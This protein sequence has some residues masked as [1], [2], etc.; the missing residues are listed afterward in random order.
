MTA[1]RKFRL[2]GIG[3]AT[4]ALVLAGTS[5]A[6]AAPS[7]VYVSNTHS[8]STACRHTPVA[9]VQQGVDLVARGGTVTVCAGSY[10]ENVTIRKPLTLR[11]LSGSVIDPVVPQGVAIRVQADHVTVTG[12]TVTGAGDGV[13]VETDF[14]TIS[15]N[16]VTDT[17]GLGIGL[18]GTRNSVV[19]NNR[20]VGTLNGIYLADSGVAAARSNRIVGN[21]VT[22]S[23]G[24]AGIWIVDDTSFGVIGNVVQGNEVD[25][26]HDFFAGGITIVV[27]SEGGGVLRDNRLMGN[28]ASGNDHA[29]IEIIVADA[30]ADVSGNWIVGNNLGTNNVARSEPGDP[31]TTGVYLDSLAPMNILVTAN[32]IHDDEV[33]VF[34]A[35]PVTLQGRTNVFRNVGQQYAETGPYIPPA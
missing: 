9:S 3:L 19:Q 16:V 26:S 30:T 6:E 11:G 14:V 20:V 21:V 22:D 25:R 15:G 34:T 17:V 24:G 31:A 32:Y 13:F 7:V 33:G 2:L 35:G 10:P 8:G 27:V 18:R 29:G 23:R 5:V 4:A 1:H 28:T 12:L